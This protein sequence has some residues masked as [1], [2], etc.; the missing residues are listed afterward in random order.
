M[1]VSRSFDTIVIGA[2]SVGV[3]TALF[4]ALE[5][6][7]V[8]VVEANFSVGQGQNK[9]AIGGV[10]ATHSDPAKIFICKESLHIFSEWKKTYGHDIGWKKGGY[11]F[12]VFDRQ[13]ENI[14]KTLLPIQQSYGLNISWLDAEGIKE[15]IPGIMEEGLIGG[16]FSPEDGQVCPLLAIDAMYRVSKE[17]GC[18]YHF[19]EKVTGL[20]IENDRVK[21]V[22]TDKDTYYAPVI[23]NA[24][25]VHAREVGKMGGLDVPVMSDSHEAGISAPIRQF[26]GPLV[27]DLRPGPE[28]KTANFYFA[29]TLEGPIIFCYTPKKLFTG[30]NSEPTSEF[31]PIV[32]RRMIN[33]IPRLK[34]ILVR[35]VWRGQY[36][37]TPDGLPIC[38]RVRE[39]EG[40]YLAVGLCGQGFMLG[41]GIGRNL[42]HLIVYG[43]PII[44]HKIFDTMSFY[45]DFYGSKKETLK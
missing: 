22:E 1:A 29:Q 40:L 44:E 13:E 2:G 24:A 18:T 34:N 10:R 25:G 20:L 21:G 38:D 32:A 33:L 31:L 30:T 41:P 35:R 19:N 12:P 45:R 6:L 16:T 39:I 26:L 17:R 42:A 28:G 7:E 3:P 8:L 14:L 23:V 5:G 27:V 43:S 15:V 11:C 4:L 9:S 36:P 37:M